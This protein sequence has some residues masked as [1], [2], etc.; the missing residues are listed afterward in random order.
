M[1]SLGYFVTATTKALENIQNR[2]RIKWN[3]VLM[4]LH[5]NSLHT[6]GLINPLQIS[7]KTGK[8][9]RDIPFYPELQACSL[10]NKFLKSALKNLENFH[11]ELLNPAFFNNFFISFSLSTWTKSTPQKNWSFWLNPYKIEVMITSLIEML[12]L[13]NFGHMT[14][15]KI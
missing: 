3:P 9:V 13:A 6:T 14:T 11:K 10:L 7:W 8:G 4:K 15:S 2:K 12:E 5:D 1:F